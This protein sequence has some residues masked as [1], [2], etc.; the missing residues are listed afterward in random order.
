MY[1]DLLM[2]RETLT[3]E[4]WMRVKV[5]AHRLDQDNILY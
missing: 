4:V 2:S 3:F 1:S 5:T